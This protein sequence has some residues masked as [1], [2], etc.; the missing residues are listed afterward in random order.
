VRLDEASAGIVRGMSGPDPAIQPQRRKRAVS[1]ILEG[2][3]GLAARNILTLLRVTA[4]LTLPLGLLFS[5]AVVWLA[6][7]SGSRNLAIGVLAPVT[8]LYVLAAIIS[9]AACLKVA[10]EAYDGGRPRAKPAIALA[11]HRIGPVVCVTLLLLVAAAPAA[12]LIALPGLKALGN[13]ALLLLI[14]AL[15]SLWASGTYSVALA[16]MLVEGRGIVSSFRRSAELVRG[17]F[18]RA[19]GTVVLGGALA[20]FAGVLVAIIVS[21]FSVGG[22]SVIAIV[23]LAGFTLGELLIAPFYVAF[24]IVLFGDLRSREHGSG[25]A[26]Q[27]S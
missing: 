3:A 8:A 27:A 19:L 20:L 13:Y 12:A 2:G 5:A 22:E 21:V 18:F 24:L 1:D 10:A 4:P 14:L 17:S 6:N 15:F 25:P 16:A 9:G 23:T 7:S 11:L 26:A